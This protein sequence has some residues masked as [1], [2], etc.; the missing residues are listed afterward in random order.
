[1]EGK[2]QA[3]FSCLKP[4]ISLDNQLAFAFTLSCA[5]ACFLQAPI[6]FPDLPVGVDP[7]DSFPEPFVLGAFDFLSNSNTF[8][9]PV[10]SAFTNL[11]LAF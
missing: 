9:T 11:S 6:Q 2:C 7:T 5:M 4:L 3:L 10:C 8:S 1:M